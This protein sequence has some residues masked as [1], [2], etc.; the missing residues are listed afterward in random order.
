MMMP[1]DISLHAGK[2]AT[3]VPSIRKPLDNLEGYLDWTDGALESGLVRAKEAFAC[4]GIQGGPPNVVALFST[5][6]TSHRGKE[7]DVAVIRKLAKITKTPVV[8]T[9]TAM[10]EVARRLN[11]KKIGL[12][13][14]YTSPIPNGLFKKFM[15]EYGAEVVTESTWD[16]HHQPASPRLIYR[17]AVKANRSDVEAIF[18]MNTGYVLGDLIEVLEA[19]LRKL[20]VGGNQVTFWAA[21][22][23]GGYRR[24]VDGYGRLFREY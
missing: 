4:G 2:F 21:C 17:Q 8:T 10:G 15:S 3:P 23:S 14:P 1:D 12:V 9:S 22:R 5:S 16:Q 13:S 24:P 19:E 11:V 7:Y 20:V 18:L 6:L